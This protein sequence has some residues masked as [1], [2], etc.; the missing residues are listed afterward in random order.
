MTAI[1]IIAA[2]IA[3]LTT[4]IALACCKAS[5]DSDKRMERS[6]NDKN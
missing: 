2:L 6:T 3:A 4:M 5:G 1:G